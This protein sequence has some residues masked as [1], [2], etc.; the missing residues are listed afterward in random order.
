MAL[1]SLN[2]SQN[3]FEQFAFTTFVAAMQ[4]NGNGVKKI[5]MR[6]SFSEK[7]KV[8]IK[9]EVGGYNQSKALVL[10]AAQQE[11]IGYLPEVLIAMVGD[12][13]DATPVEFIV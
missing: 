7:G 9:E 8:K 6:S 4:L 2:I 3:I 12:Y 10:E 11:L 5:Y 1:E 13:Y